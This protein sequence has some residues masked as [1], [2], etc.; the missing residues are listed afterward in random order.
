MEKNLNPTQ[1]NSTQSKNEIC[2]K[3]TLTGLRMF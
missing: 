2:Y 3:V 1:L